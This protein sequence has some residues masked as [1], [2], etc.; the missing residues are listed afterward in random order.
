M[1]NKAGLE[2]CL[3]LCYAPPKAWTE[4]VDNEETLLLFEDVGAGKP[5]S[6]PDVRRTAFTNGSLQHSTNGQCDSLGGGL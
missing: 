4:S 3:V 2:S 6:L 1:P 5:A